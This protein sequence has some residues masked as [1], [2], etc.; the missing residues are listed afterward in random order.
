MPCRKLL[1]QKGQLSSREG[2][3][4][5]H[6]SNAAPLTPHPSQVSACQLSQTSGPQP[7]VLPTRSQQ[8]RGN[9]TR[10][11]Q[12]WDAYGTFPFHQQT[13]CKL[14]RVLISRPQSC[15]AMLLIFVMASLGLRL[16]HLRPIF[17][18]GNSTEAP[19]PLKHLTSSLF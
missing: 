3:S 2:I 13:G 14:S 19:I 6:Q 10:E 18:Q 1:R 7:S 16:S 5:I 4:N 8:H 15:N 17:W 9:A 11:C 12:P